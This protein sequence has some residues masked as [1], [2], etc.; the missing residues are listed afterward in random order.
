MGSKSPTHRRLLWL[1]FLA[2][3]V[4]LGSFAGLLSDLTR[5]SFWAVFAGVLSASL[6]SG[7]LALWWLGLWATR[8]G[9]RLGQ[10]GIGS[11]LFLT[12]FVAI[13]LGAVRWLVIGAQRNLSA[14]GDG[15]DF[16][17]E[18]DLFAAIAVTVLIL[19]AFSIPALVVL[20]EGVLWAAVWLVRRP[21]VQGLLAVIRRALRA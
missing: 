2:G 17:P 8:P 7:S 1:R 11:L 21:F 10:F 6:I 14:R 3:V 9:S 4:W 18:M 20:T 19:A 5:L 15:A 12:A 16:A 13:Y